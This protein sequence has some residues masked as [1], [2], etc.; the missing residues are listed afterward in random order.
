MEQRRW[1]LT[2][3]QQEKRNEQVLK[4]AQDAI[5][6]GTYQEHVQPSLPIDLNHRT[7]RDLPVPSDAQRFQEKQGHIPTPPQ[8]PEDPNSYYPKL[9][10]PSAQPTMA[11]HYR[12][13]LQL[14]LRTQHASN[15]DLPDP[16]TREE[17]DYR[18]YA[19]V[20]FPQC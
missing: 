12:R 6:A 17:Q 18:D 1:W 7:N 19:H 8:I 20:L 10:K 5:R 15:I 16:I 9:H 4:Q 14:F 2:P 3:K 13:D 11:T